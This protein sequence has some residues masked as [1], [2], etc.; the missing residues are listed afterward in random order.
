MSGRKRMAVVHLGWGPLG[1]APLQR[2]LD[3]YRRHPPGVEHELVLLLNGTD[4]DGRDALEQ[5]SAG[6]PHRTVALERPGQ[7][8]DA[9]VQAATLLGHDRLCF[10]NSY[11]EVL[12][13]DWLAK[14]STALDQRDIGIAGAT[15]SWTSAF[16]T[17][18]DALRLPN[19]YPNRLP[20]RADIPPP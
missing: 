8:L 12:A 2:F 14:L 17:L 18:L 11:S 19:P 4:A 20:P 5:V 9:Y 13:D 3:S 7:D 15:G 16:S 1:P 6:T 10:L